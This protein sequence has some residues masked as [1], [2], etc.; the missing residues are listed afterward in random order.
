M[1]PANI[2]AAIKHIDYPKGTNYVKRNKLPVVEGAV[3][4]TVYFMG[5]LQ[6]HSLMYLFL[7]TNV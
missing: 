1:L 6:R 2:Y 5:L 3:A 7:K 4:G